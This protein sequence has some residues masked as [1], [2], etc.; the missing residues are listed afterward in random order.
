[1]NRFV[2]VSFLLTI[3]FKQE[4]PAIRTATRTNERNM[5]RLIKFLTTLSAWVVYTSVLL[6]VVPSSCADADAATA[7]VG[8]LRNDPS[9]KRDGY[10]Y[11]EF[12][13]E[14]NHNKGHPNSNSNNN[15]KNKNSSQDVEVLRHRHRNRG[16]GDI[17]RSHTSRRLVPDPRKKKKRDTNSSPS[18]SPSK[19]NNKPSGGVSNSS[20][21]S[22]SSSSSLSA[23]P[24]LR[25]SS[26]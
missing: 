6:Q 7:V 23:K 5:A 18:S 14:R 24:S 1:M 2:I 3:I 21:S 9:A 26:S 25:N 19:K 22:T 15:T 13:L 20:S 10:Y 12:G 4:T 8:I 11:N 17:N 16:K